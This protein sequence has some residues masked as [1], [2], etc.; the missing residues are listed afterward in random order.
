VIVRSVAKDLDVPL[1]G[2]SHFS[3]RGAEMMARLV[4]MGIREADL[5][6]AECLK[7]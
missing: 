6:I 3:P 2:S 1:I 5:G 4:M 7:E